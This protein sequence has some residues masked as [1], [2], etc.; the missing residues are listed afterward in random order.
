MDRV[1][2][3]RRKMGL[4]QVERGFSLF[5]AKFLPYLMIFQSWV[6]QF[7]KE[8][9]SYSSQIF[10][11]FDDFSKCSMPMALPYTLT[12]NQISMAKIWGE[13][14]K[15]LGLTVNPKSKFWAL[16][17]SLGQ[18]GI[19]GERGRMLRY[20]FPPQQFSPSPFCLSF[21]LIAWYGVLYDE[22]LGHWPT[23]LPIITLLAKKWLFIYPWH[24]EYEML[25]LM[26]AG[27]DAQCT[28]V[29]KNATQL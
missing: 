12:N 18:S 7:E 22:V 14:K 13:M 25:L 9:S 3:V 19:C 1:P 8:F 5:F 6:L 20:T 21:L 16:D 29:E 26:R 17:S 28:K 24:L 23:W 15:I 27:A 2:A 10:T 4:K 11:I